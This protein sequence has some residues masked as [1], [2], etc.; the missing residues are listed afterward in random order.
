[1]PEVCLIIPCYNEEKRLNV[2]VFEHFLLNHSNYHLLFVDDGS[3]DD[4]DQIL[5]G[6]VHRFPNA[7]KLSL[8]KNSG[9]AQAVREGILS[10]IAKQD[11]HFIGYLD[12]DLATPFHEILKMEDVFKRNPHFKIMLGSRWKRLGVQINR[13]WFRHYLGRIFATVVSLLFNI[14]VYDTQ[15]GAK[16]LANQSLDK[17]FQEKFK[18]S[19]FFDIE[20]LLRLIRQNPDIEIDDWA[21]EVPLEQWSEVAGSRIKIIDF[22]LVPVH[23]MRIKWHYR[24][25]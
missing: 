3:T 18:S 4:T 21:A 15:C 9:K 16:L 17:I 25:H 7:F 10:A 5:T 1:M 8:S 13:T 2:P 22:L 14:N 12:A 11:Y 19:W 23:L 24:N 6:I 20:I